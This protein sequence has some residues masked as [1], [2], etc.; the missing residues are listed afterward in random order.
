MCCLVLQDEDVVPA[1]DSVNMTGTLASASL[2]RRR[3]ERVIN[4]VFIK[5]HAKPPWG[6]LDQ[7]Q[8]VRT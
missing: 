4:P 8:W 2:V 5:D 6:E 7:K 3:Q 1:A